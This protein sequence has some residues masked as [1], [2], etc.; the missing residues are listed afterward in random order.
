MLSESKYDSKP[1]AKRELY[2]F[3][4]LHLPNMQRRLESSLLCFRA[5]VKQ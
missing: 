3:G 4:E 2:Y 1:Q 5:V